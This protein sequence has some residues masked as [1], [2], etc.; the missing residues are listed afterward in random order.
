MVRSSSPRRMWVENL[1]YGELGLRGKGFGPLPAG[2]A[3]GP[4]GSVADRAAGM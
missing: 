4:A 2:R 3:T 1:A